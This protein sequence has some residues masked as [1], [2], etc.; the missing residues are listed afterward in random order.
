MMIK[1]RIV[2]SNFHI[3]TYL[4]V[5]G[6]N[7]ESFQNLDAVTWRYCTEVQLGIVL[8]E[9]KSRGSHPAL[10]LGVDS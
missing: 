4:S 8:S 5:S 9:N 6:E 10:A 3:L 2:P 1:V 7:L